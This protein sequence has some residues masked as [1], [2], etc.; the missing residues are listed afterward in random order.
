MLPTVAKHFP[1]GRLFPE[2]S[3]DS[4]SGVI[5]LVMVE[6]LVPLEETTANPGLFYAADATSGK[7]VG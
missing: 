6:S 4:P 1:P 7:P 5:S 3:S 2:T